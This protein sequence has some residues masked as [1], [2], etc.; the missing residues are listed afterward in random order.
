M[1][2][3]IQMII[4]TEVVIPFPYALVILIHLCAE[5]GSGKVTKTYWEII[6]LKAMLIN[7]N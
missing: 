5:C 6:N 3:L 1:Y 2:I 4:G 7:K